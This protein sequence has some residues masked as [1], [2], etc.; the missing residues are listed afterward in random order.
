ME[1]RLQDRITRQREKISILQR[2]LSKIVLI[3]VVATGIIALLLILLVSQNQKNAEL[4]KKLELKDGQQVEK[5]ELKA[6]EILQL[7]A[8]ILELESENSKLN[9]QIFDLNQEIGNL[10]SELLAKEKQIIDSQQKHDEEMKQYHDFENEVILRTLYCEVGGEGEKAQLAAAATIFN[11]TVSPEFPDTILEVIFQPNRFSPV[12]NGKIWRTEIPEK[13]R[14][15]LQN[16]IA[17]AK[18]GEDP[19]RAILGGVGALYFYA[20]DGLSEDQRE[21]RASIRTTVQFSNTVFY[22]IW[23]K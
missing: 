2:Y 22:R 18:A 14:E 10:N 19:T 20:P 15:S 1:Q 9:E 17:R 12:S 11:S 21:R 3:L 6:H 7:E 13:S 4:S 8:R 23:D 5:V 16:I